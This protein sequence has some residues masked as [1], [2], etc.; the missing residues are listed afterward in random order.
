MALPCSDS[1]LQEPIHTS[2]IML[3]EKQNIHYSLDLH[4]L[5]VCYVEV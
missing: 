1:A 3:V 2:T 4:H 5:I